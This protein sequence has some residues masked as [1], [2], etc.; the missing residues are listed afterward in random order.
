VIILI[1]L[2]V[3]GLAALMIIPFQVTG[4]ILNAKLSYDAID[5]ADYGLEATD[6]SLVTDDGLT[7]A[8]YLVEAETPKGAIVLISG[9]DNPPVRDFYSY[10]KMFQDAGFSTL[11]VE[12]RS[13]GDSEG[14][15]ISMGMNEWL[16]VKAGAEYL[17][18]LEDYKDLPIIA[19]GTSMGAGTVI[20]AGAQVDAIDAVISA[21][22]FTNWGDLA[23]FNMLAMGLSE[24]Y[25]A[26]QK[27]FMD[28]SMGLKFGLGKMKYTPINQIKK[29]DKP[30]LLM[31]SKGDTQVPYECFEALN[32]AAFR[33][34]NADVSNVYIYTLAGDNHFVCQ[35]EY[36]ENPTEDIGFSGAVLSF[37]TQ[38]GE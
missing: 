14:F 3:L 34:E 37:L 32:R 24:G 22:A 11:L 6:V 21:S 16:D 27:P 5:A 17:E 12:M 23:S 33:D 18:G 13:H 26:I 20:I 9:L 30:I 10:A 2:L 15:G 29:L 35:E 38:F 19:Y 4:G 1:V 8:A 28:L 25:V 7:L 31:H 36:L